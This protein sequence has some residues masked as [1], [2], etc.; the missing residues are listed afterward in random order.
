MGEHLIKP[1]ELSIWEDR[2]IINEDNTKYFKEF[3]IAVLGSDKMTS[4]QR[5]M[6][7]VLTENVNGEKTLTFSLASK[8]FNPLTGEIE[9]NP[10]EKYLVNERKIKLLYGDKWYEFV[11]KTKEESSEEYIYNYTARELFVLELSKVGYDVVLDQSLNNNQ[12]TIT[13]LASKVLEGTDWKLDTQNTD[14]LQ[15]LVQD[16]IYDGTIVA[17][18]GLSVINLDTNETE[19]LPVNQK[20]YL[21]YS[22][23]ANKT[24][25][26]VQFMCVSPTGKE[27]VDDNCVITST[28]YR[29]NTEVIYEET[30]NGIDI[31]SDVESDTKPILIHLDGI[32]YQ[33]QGYRLVY[34]P[35]TT[36]DPVM[37]RT[38]DIYE[39]NYDDQK[40][41]IYH[42]TDYNYAT[43]QIVASFLTNSNNF[44]IY[45]N[46]DIQ[47][48]S[49][50][51]ELSRI[52]GD[53]PVVQ[54][55][56]FV[57]DPPVNNSVNLRST[58]MLTSVEGFLQMKFHDVLGPNYENTYFN[59]GF[60]DAASMI[61]HITAG[62]EFVLR[63]R[64]KTGG[65]TVEN[66]QPGAGGIRAIVAQ[67]TEEKDENELYPYYL[68][69]EAKTAD[70]PLKP[71][72]ITVRKINPGG[73]IL[74][75]D[76][77]FELS[78]NI[79]CNGSFSADF[80]KYIV[81]DVVQVPSTL[82]CY[83]DKNETEATA[84]NTYIWSNDKN[85][86]ILKDDKYAD[87]YLTTTKARIS[88]TNKVIADPLTKIGVF[89]YVDDPNL[90]GDN[91]YIYLQDIQLTRCY[92]DNG[93]I[94]LQGN[95][96]TATSIIKDQFYIK[97]LKNITA[98]EINLYESLDD[99]ARVL[100]VERDSIKRTYNEN[101]EKILSI[102]ASRSNIFNILQS[103]CET[104][105]CWLSINVEHEPNGAIRLDK[106][107]NP[108]K[109]I[110]FKQYAGKDNFAGFR[111]GI[112]LESIQRTFE[113]EELVTKLIV[114][115]VQSEFTS[116][117]AVDI[118]HARSNPSGQSYILNFSY[119]QNQKL[120]DTEEVNKDISNL[121]IKLKQINDE[122]HSQSVDKATLANAI[123]RVQSKYTVIDN[124]VHKTIDDYEEAVV[125][126]AEATGM[127]YEVFVSHYNNLEDYI[128]DKSEEEED[129]AT[130]L[131][132]ND[133]IIEI[134]GK[135]YTYASA[136]NNYT[137]ILTNLEEEYNNLTLEY[138][139]AKEYGISV[140]VNPSYV[141][142][143]MPVITTIVV[144]DYLKGLSFKLY[145][146]DETLE[147]DTNINTRIFEINSGIP[148][149]YFVVTRIPEHYRL[150]IFENNCSYYIE[151]D[152]LENAIFT[153]YNENDSKTITRRFKLV[154]DEDW[155][156]KHPGYEGREA[157]L[158]EEKRQLEKEFYTKYSRYIQEGTWTSQDY[159]D[160]ELYYLDALQVSNTS[161]QPKA[162]YTIKV[163]EI[164][165]TPERNNYYFEVGDKTYIED[166]EFFG[167]QPER[168]Q[169]LSDGTQLIVKTPI[170]EEVIVSEVEWHLDAPD[171][172]VVTIQNYKTR[173]EDLF[174][175]ISAAVQTV[176][177][178]EA[179]YAKTSAILDDNGNIKSE[180]LSESMMNA[181]GNGFV[182]TSDG[183]I[184]TDGK[185]LIVQDLTNNGNYVRIISGGIQIS[186]D[187]GKT[188]GTALDANGI[189]TDVLTAGTINTQN[190]W[191]MDGD[192]PSFRW[193]K[194]GLNAYGLDENGNQAYDL[195]TYVRFDKY[196]LYGVKNGEDFVAS[197]LDNV[198]DTAFFGITWDGFFIKNSYTDN[199]EV[200]ITSE[201]D[202]VVKQ[203]N[204]DRIKIGAI[205]KPTNDE[206]G[207]YGIRIKNADGES[208]FETG[209][210]GNIT[211]T[212]T[213]NATNGLFSGI[214]A[215]GNNDENHV[216]IDGNEATIKSSN[217]SGAGGLGWAINGEGD[218]YFSNV[219]VRGAIKTA[220]FEYEEIQ[221]VGGAFLFRPSSS[222]K[223]AR[224]VPTEVTEIEDGVEVTRETYYHYEN[225]EVVYNDLYLIVEKPLVFRVG[226]WCKISN[227]ASEKAPVP[228]IDNNFLGSTG[229][230]HIYEITAIDVNP[231][232]EIYPDDEEEA[233][234]YTNEICLSGGAAILEVA[235][236][237][238]LAGG[239]L[240]DF[241]SHAKENGI[242][243]PG[244]YNYGIGVNSS[245]NYVN[246]PPRAISLFE[247]I[248]HPNNTIKVSYNY[249][250]I[251]GTLPVMSS[252]VN[253]NVYQYM[254]G[255]QG[256]YTDN[257]Y[258]GDNNQYIAFYEDGNHNKQLKIK[259]N[260]IMF[261]I[262]DPGPDEDPWKD[263]SEVAEGADGE[264]A[265]TVRIDSN[266]GNNFVYSQEEADLTCTVIKG[267]STDITDQVLRFLW[268]KT[269]IN[270]E[271]DITWNS[272][273]QNYNQ[274]TIRIY[275]SDISVKA[276]FNCQVTF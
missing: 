88:Y 261:E 72:Y 20:I 80:T 176:Q 19:N 18:D 208:V 122:I 267:N 123:T 275:P 162:S 101:S 217:Y 181:V 35:L 137:G 89:L 251:L 186:S 36:Y 73:I 259:A 168:I 197:S 38:V 53:T 63:A 70:P 25:K 112:N 57:T 52:E 175:R 94:I 124:L 59:S 37:N 92:R 159:V 7:L 23:V 152:N 151:R 257:M 154:P 221:A 95:V 231:H 96:P 126:F 68:S 84:E 240:L 248:I 163:A 230:T 118:Q 111:Y 236:L 158:I 131:A 16:P 30:E 191:L 65:K 225:G 127:T 219:S 203:N 194:A 5:A 109:K 117:G 179:T 3:K 17:A 86:Y 276:I 105:E 166:V 1:Y 177:Y 69:E 246:L 237:E 187:G 160:P 238:D 50:R 274:R 149:N 58:N 77:N 268:T 192:N 143:G 24:S 39:A 138:N 229:L 270:G 258:I 102:Q 253:Q 241:G 199:G 171:E 103:L 133:T 174:Q 226:S 31:K 135:I 106:N 256:I 64:F 254:Q 87:Y 204:I 90:V 207:K 14:L 10:L 71:S 107:Y 56:T 115:P 269:L 120:I 264:D 125:D 33:Y 178:N 272:A 233:I 211:V 144:D 188:W 155:L 185:G 29:L 9:K 98:N 145:N 164:S 13:E 215:V 180:L 189:S 228:T 224:Y 34:A 21:F 148:Y 265:I 82:Y 169:D 196:G 121:N 220:V 235:T 4:P 104:F 60:E 134:I 8:Y 212:G 249:R 81:D 83:R 108:I 218:A 136:I 250:G 142:D 2:L 165:E 190:I 223:S 147:Y 47:G 26:Y 130:S 184:R 132:N 227:Y 113:S 32:N 157:Q 210:D 54:P 271:P 85:Q 76:G 28:N 146:N 100:G 214:V 119:F 156:Q 97:P 114:E 266:V 75:F 44:N 242:D 167:Y 139:G 49:A 67:Y 260:Q 222:I 66:L 74:N 263:I 273:H 201:D 161:A 116:A 43:S 247:T 262:S 129:K 128:A 93:E 40:Q 244:G 153:I 46:G 6:N 12:G 99:L 170:Q 62:E 255:T 216:V 27:V 51:T 200:S 195:K 245:D 243:V 61:D 150:E 141:Q 78:E 205:V 239:S 110:A 42:Y 172:N 252:G 11:I 15:Q 45:E 79:I 91:K 55:L 206:P 48:W 209:D 140:G 22:Y 183:T 182:L 202:F 193:D 198:R 232:P 234:E 41:T 213:I 173:F